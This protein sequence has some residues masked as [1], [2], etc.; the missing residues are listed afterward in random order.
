MKSHREV[1]FLFFRMKSLIEHKRNMQ[2]SKTGTLY[3]FRSWSNENH[4]NALLKGEFFLSSPK[5]FNDPF[6]CQIFIDYSTL[7][8]PE[9]RDVYIASYFGRLAG[10]KS[11]LERITA[12]ANER[13][14]D[15]VKFQEESDEIE[16]V[17]YQ[18]LTGILSLAKTWK[19]ILMWSHYADNHKGYCVGLNMDGLKASGKFGRGDFVQY[20]TSYPKISPDISGFDKAWQQSM[21]KS[22]CWEYEEEYRLVKSFGPDTPTSDERK[23]Y[24]ADEISEVTLGLMMPEKHKQEIIEF[25]KLKGIKVYQ[26]KKVPFKF[27]IDREE[28]S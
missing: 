1:A 28:L 3:K 17:T 24:L 8:T 6:D 11:E 18:K 20:D 22:K 7:D 15:I 9:K 27:E 5:Y 2:L 10:S 14:R 21:T 25:A 26:A 19:P 12:R 4:R 23:L 13:M 16:T